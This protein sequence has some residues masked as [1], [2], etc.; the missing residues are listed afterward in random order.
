MPT[1]RE[2]GSRYFSFENPDDFRLKIMAAARAHGVNDSEI[3]DRILIC[4]ARVVPED[5]AKLLRKAGGEFAFIVVDT[6]Q[7]GFDGDDSN[8]NVQTGAYMRRLRPLC[9]LPG[10]PAVVVAAH[11][12]KGAQRDNLAPYGGG[13]VV[14]EVDGNLTLWKADGK[15]I[16]ELHWQV[17]F[18]GVPFDP[19]HF[20]I[21]AHTCP[22]LLDNKGR[23][24]RLPV[25]KHLPASAAAV[26][27]AKAER[28]AEDEA[29]ALMKEIDSNP[30]AS[31]KVWGQA[32]GRNA[33]TVSRRLEC[34]EADKLAE[35]VAGGWRLT[36]KGKKQI[37]AADEA[38]TAKFEVVDD[39]A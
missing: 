10:K 28:K 22:D 15:N 21:E 19:V 9:A 4:D 2:A 14:N 24:L 13:A 6:L 35:R 1:Q 3:G 23:A 30:G 37:T 20:T 5:M 25:V 11:P 7:A 27:A 12:V 33:S 16:A 32:I 36:A 18:R 39:A 38:D 34:F 17:K 26:V 8:N 29:V 31:L